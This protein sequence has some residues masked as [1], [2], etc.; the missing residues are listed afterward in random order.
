MGCRDLTLAEQEDL[1]DFFNSD[2]LDPS[3]IYHYCI[4]GVCRIRCNNDENTSCKTSQRLGC[5]AVSRGGIPVPLEY[6]WKNL[7]PANGKALRSKVMFNTGVDALRLMWTPQKRKEAAAAML[8]ADQLGVESTYAVKN[9]VR[10]NAVLTYFEVE[11]PDV[12]APMIAAAV[13]SPSEGVLDEILSKRGMHLM[14]K[15]CSIVL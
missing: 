8:A 7:E 6:R 10:A 4:P 11:D 2:W 15:M 5:A 3:A 12:H 1:L 9:G 13:A 14:C